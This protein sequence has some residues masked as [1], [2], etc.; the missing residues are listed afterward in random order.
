M[1]V[2]EGSADQGIR[3]GTDSGLAGVGLGAQ[4]AVITRR[5]VGFLWIRANPSGGIADALIVAL[6]ECSA[7][8][9]IRANADSGLAG[10]GLGAQIIVIARC[11]L[12]CG[13]V[14]AEP[15]R[16]IA[17]ADVMTLI[18]GA[19]DRIGADTDSGLAGVG[20]GTEVTVVAR[21]SIGGR[22]VGTLTGARVAHSCIVTRIQSR[23]DDRIGA[24]TDSG[25]AGVGLRAEVP[26]VARRAVRRRWVGAD[27]GSRVADARVVALIEGG[28]DDGIRANT[29]A[30]HTS[31]ALRTQIA[32]IAGRAVRLWR[33]GAETRRGIAD[34]GFVTFASNAHYRI[35]SSTAARLANVGRCTEVTVVARCAVGLCRVRAA[36][37]CRVAHPGFMTL[38]NSDADDGSCPDADPVLTGVG[39]GAEIGVVTGGAIILLRV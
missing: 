38:V 23:A 27:A 28:A 17:H 21:F 11:P 32:I 37:R 16:G 35:Q 31:V 5:T 13:R 15:G 39:L 14:R 3:A 6:V 18:S 30:S 2:V 10:V 20:L 7:D 25:L 1:T 19:D 26:V 4:I 8:H 29:A 12:V 22:W 36:S 34:S 24:D 33:F 9:W